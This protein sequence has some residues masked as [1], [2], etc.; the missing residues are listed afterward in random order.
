MI[1]GDTSD[2]RRTDMEGPKETIST[3]TSTLPPI[4]YGRSSL[5]C[6]PRSSWNSS[7]ATEPDATLEKDRH[8]SSP[9]AVNDPEPSLDNNENADNYDN[10]DDDDDDDNSEELR[11][12][13]SAA[14]SPDN[15]DDSS[16]EL[17]AEC[18]EDQQVDRNQVAADRSTPS[19]DNLAPL[20]ALSS[21][22]ASVLGRIAAGFSTALSGGLHPL[23]RSVRVAPEPPPSPSPRSPSPKDFFWGPV[24]PGYP[25]SLP[26]VDETKGS[27]STMVIRQTVQLEQTQTSNNNADAADIGLRQAIPVMSMYLA[28]FCCLLNAISPGLGKIINQAVDL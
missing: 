13:T 3:S 28:V 16:D 19:A 17:A 7:T 6:N 10:Y 21:S 9:D 20:S 27:Q 4:E 15:T 23:E 18:D 12:L 22:S 14:A 1:Y 26:D 24:M 5:V 8:E 2:E 11:A 25:T